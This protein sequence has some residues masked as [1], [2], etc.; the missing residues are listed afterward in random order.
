MRK[1]SKFDETQEKTLKYTINIFFTG[2]FSQIV[3]DEMRVFI[4]EV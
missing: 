4:D 1:K 2:N 3:I